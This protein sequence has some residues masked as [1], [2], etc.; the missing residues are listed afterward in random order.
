MKT[1][2]AVEK[3]L[4]S[5]LNTA[6]VDLLCTCLFSWEADRPRPILYS[7]SPIHP[8]IDQIKILWH[9]LV[10]RSRSVELCLQSY[11]SRCN[12]WIALVRFPTVQDFL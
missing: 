1:D 11:F 10:V 5:V 12:D 7:V 9:F 6:T 8:M 3:E 4:V 2:V